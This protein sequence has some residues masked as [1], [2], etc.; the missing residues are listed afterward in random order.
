MGRKASFSARWRRVYRLPW[1]PVLFFFHSLL[2]LFVFFSLRFVFSR[3]GERCHVLPQGHLW[4]IQ[5]PWGWLPSIYTHTHTYTLTH[6]LTHSHTHLHTHTHTQIYTLTHTH[7]HTH[8]HTR[9]TVGRREE[10]GNEKKRRDELEKKHS[11]NSTR[12]IEN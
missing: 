12:G 11:T 5:T 3:S 9:R 8:T 4:L 2:R 10:L 1:R 7:L 6:T